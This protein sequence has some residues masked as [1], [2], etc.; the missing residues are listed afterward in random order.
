MIR[1][2]FFIIF[3]SAVILVLGL[4][5]LLLLRSLNKPWWM[6]RW[7]RR[8]AYLLPLNGVLM[9]VTL[10]LAEYYRVDWLAA[11]AA[12]L[13]VLAIV[14]EACLMFS[15]PVSGAIHLTER[16]LERLA[17]RRPESEDRRPDQ[18][19]RLLLRGAATLVPVA[20]VSAG[21]GGVGRA[22]ARAE[23]R[24][25]VF[26]FDNLPAD[27]EGL[28]VLHL[29][30]LHLR[31]YV[32]LD[33]LARI[34]TDASAYQP[35]LILV[36]G[37]VAD[38]LDQLGDTLRLISEANPPLGCFATLG[39]HEYFRGV[40]TVKA[41][42][43]N[44]GVR[45]L[46]DRCVRLVVGKS[47]ICLGGLDDPVT[48]R[49]I[50]DSFYPT[51]LRTTFLDAAAD[52]FTI[53]MSHRPDAFQ[54]A[55]KRNIDLTLAGHTHGAQIGFGG[56]SLLESSLPDSF[57]WGKYQQGQSQLYTSC[58][59]GH[60]FPFRLGCPTEAPIIQLMRR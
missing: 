22:Y 12:P 2:F 52:D 19:R 26:F 59:A 39:N 23:V 21:L 13:T 6:K 45:L 20:A 33:D 7:V 44:S 58:G 40:Q 34:L 35:D 5:Q 46:V 10:S 37:D 15:M 38:D 43:A 16:V 42:Y 31:H 28:R 60:W 17:R 36:T 11:C 41:V 54:H 9:L 49:R 24:R 32:T 53:L 14:L 18:R 50:P 25:E 30:D 4:I 47:T 48:M 57:L 3:V 27:L 51:G 56:R 29:T 55:A 8:S 1:V